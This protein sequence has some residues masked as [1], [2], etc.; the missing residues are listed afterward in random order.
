MIGMGLF[1]SGGQF[2]D[3]I[4]ATDGVNNGAAALW[5]N[6]GL[7]AITTVPGLTP[8][9]A[10]IY[11]QTVPDSTIWNYNRLVITDNGHVGIGTGT[12]VPSTTVLE[13][14]SNPPGYP[15]DV[16][17]GPGSATAA[18][19]YIFGTVGWNLGFDGTNWDTKTDGVNNGGAMIWSNTDGGLRFTTVPSTGTVSQSIADNN[20]PA[21]TRMIITGI[22]NI[23][24]GTT[25]PSAA[26]E[27]NNTLAPNI[28]IGQYEGAN[29][30]RVDNTG[31]GFFQGGVQTGGAD[32]A[33][34]L[35]V[36]GRRAEYEPGDLLVI[37]PKGKRRLAL[38]RTAYSPLVA[39]IYSTK[40]GVLA[41]PHSMD[42]GESRDEVPLAIVGIVP[43]KV[44]AQNGPIE[45]GDLLVSSALPGYAMKATD[46]SRMLGAVVGKAL[47][48]LGKGIGV[49]Q[50]LVTLQ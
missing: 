35:A 9:G 3:W 39:G 49:I 43:C 1:R 2:S 24:I 25:T 41:T 42:D 14:G 48:P 7:F 21:D 40:P 38:S 20:I 45:A 8:G 32:F 4:A 30:F 31:K 17:I 15:A 11:D 29:E 44:T 36:R 13:V 47:E 37:D 19:G 12:L 10:G 28:L 46:R 27:V 50:V 18:D 22:G 5:A 16:L 6:S 34:S 23:G 33:E 26:L